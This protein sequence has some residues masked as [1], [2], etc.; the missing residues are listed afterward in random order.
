MENAQR[1][2][3]QVGQ[4]AVDT[5]QIQIGDPAHIESGRDDL[6]A[7]LSMPNGDGIYPIYRLTLDDGMTFYAVRTCYVDPETG[8]PFNV[9]DVFP[10]GDQQG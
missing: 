5:G 4:V 6:G 7:T 9:G 8:K 3:E 1:Y 2:L 10:R